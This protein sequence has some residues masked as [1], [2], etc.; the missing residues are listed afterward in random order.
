MAAVAGPTLKDSSQQATMSSAGPKD[1]ATTGLT[2]GG[3]PIIPATTPHAHTAITLRIQIEAG[4]AKAGL[5][6]VLRG[7]MP[8]K[9]DEIVVVPMDDIPQPPAHETRNLLAYRLQSV[10]GVKNS[11]S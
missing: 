10:A 2:A 6:E 8:P 1:P 3:L 9:A 11:R 7:G 4:Y 5:I